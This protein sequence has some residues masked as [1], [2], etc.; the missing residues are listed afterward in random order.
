MWQSGQVSSQN[1]SQRTPG[2]LQHGAHLPQSAG[3]HGVLG[4]SPAGL[5]GQ[6]QGWR[7][8]PAGGSA[9]PAASQQFATAGGLLLQAQYLPVAVSLP[10]GLSSAGLQ[11]QQP[12]LLSPAQYSLGT[13][14]VQTLPQAVQP[15]QWASAQTQPSAW[16]ISHSPPAAQQQQLAQQH[17]HS[18]LSHATAQLQLQQHLHLHTHAHPQLHQQQLQL[19]QQQQHQ[20][21]Q[22][23]H[24][25]GLALAPQPGGRGWG[26]QHLPYG[27]T[28]ALAAN[29]DAR[30][31]G[32]R[33][34]AAGGG[35]GG[36]G[37][38][39]MGY[40]QG[41]GGRGGRGGG[42]T[43]GA[44]GAGG[45][46]AGGG[47]YGRGSG[48]GGSW[49][50][51]YGSAGGSSA[52][53]VRG[54]YGGGGGG[55]GGGYG[56]GGGGG[57]SGVSGPHVDALIHQLFMS[58]RQLPR[59]QPA[60]EA[61]A[62]R[63]GGLDGRSVAALMKQL[64]T[65]GL[66]GAA[67]EIF[68]WLRGLDHGHELDRLLDVYLFTAM[69]SLCSSNRR[70]LD[71]ALS[72][73]REMVARGVP[74]NV[75]TF[76]ALMNVCIKAGQHQAALDVWR[77]LQEAG[78]RPNVV[79]YNTLIDVYG[80]TGQWAEALKVLARMKE[81]GMEPVTRTY[82]T[83]MIACN[84][85]NQWHEALSVY[86]QLVAAGQAPNTTTYNALI[87][88]YS[89]AGRLEKVMETLREME[90]AGCER[91]VITYSALISACE[92]DGQWELA[93]QMFGQMLREG[94]NPN[95][96]TYNSLITALAA[97]AQWERAADV[98]NQL[99]RQGC[100]P[101]VVTYTALIN[102]YEKGGQWRRA[103]QAFKRLLQQGCRTDHV[104]FAAIA[105][106]LWDSG[107]ASAHARAA[108]IFRAAVAS[109]AIKPVTAAPPPSASSGATSTAGTTSTNSSGAVPVAGAGGVPPAA[110][111]A[112]GAA[113]ASGSGSAAGAGAGSLEP[114][115]EVHLGAMASGSCVAAF[116][117]F[118][119]EQRDRAIEGGPEALPPRVVLRFARAR[120]GRDGG[121]LLPLRDAL[122]AWLAARGAPFKLAQDFGPVAA[123][124][125]EALGPDLAAWLFSDAAA[126][127]LLPFAAGGAGAP[128]GGAAGG[129][130][131]ALVQA[132]LEGVDEENSRDAALEA[133]C[134]D[135]FAEVRA[136]EATH[137]LSVAAMG[138]AYLAR[139]RELTANLLDVHEA[140]VAAAAGG[141]AGGAGG[142]GSAGGVGGAGAGGPGGA[143][144]GGGALPLPRVAVH[145]AVLLLDRFMSS[146]PALQDNLLTMAS[147]TALRMLASA[148]H[149]AEH[150]AAAGHAGA[151]AAAEAAEAALDGL[152][153]AVTGLPTLG[154]Q[155]MEVNVRSA[156][157]GD[158]AAISA[159][160]CVRLYLRR[161]GAT[162]E[163]AGEAE[164]MELLDAALLDGEFLNYR[165]S[166]T[167]A[168]A[169]YAHRLRRG[170]TPPWPAAAAAL[171]GYAD[172]DHPELAAA[173]GAVQRLLME[174]SSSAAYAA[175]SRGAGAG[176]RSS[177]DVGAGAGA[178]AQPA[179]A[180]SPD[181]A[182]GGDEALGPEAAA[183]S[184]EA[185]DAG[186]GGT[187]AA[188]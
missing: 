149:A 107:T 87:T 124:R 23:V 140:V 152:L 59:G 131:Q 119:A 161:L 155:S 111:E 64:S 17:Q 112:G 51:G 43:G 3:E 88:A 122:Q 120:G 2:S 97:G 179:P 182:T 6:L 178:R 102:A 85:S 67:W 129:G 81:E 144:G 95:I 98:F 96:I 100:E 80:K 75:H 8:L 11:Q 24:P 181:G 123:Q 78:C 94:C 121:S 1:T 180:A 116:M 9:A 101:D 49:R 156:L 60:H 173:V 34:G 5:G 82:N 146:G 42:H 20:Q 68:D 33:D 115:Q 90:A 133:D 13:A 138:P 28:D 137:C 171:T 21:Q 104:V 103:L 58:V 41:R 117:C 29:T 7:I 166:A 135:A 45:Y 61:V 172:L 35:T 185:G 65:N 148:E 154:F 30:S 63:M 109:G 76:S 40:G 71:V 118:L 130:T 86:A 25:P 46:G 79:T 113:G 14:A 162:P 174:M 26:G 56:G 18:Q 92:R 10:P 153:A 183:A 32:G 50:G 70:D 108:R 69:I 188:Q 114:L 163:A 16:A 106:A 141:A 53:S 77:E 91:T 159:G 66:A 164:L 136:F 55:Y 47:R 37:A 128:E 27:R 139:R 73:S 83:L 54:G 150:A 15:Q 38:G 12:T 177:A 52:G 160:R 157:A 127:E 62:S 168:A 165:P 176:A 167:A 132:A 48:G 4:T 158:T 31:S 169:L 145:D 110:A 142:G 72:L 151:A 44:G 175:S 143:G 184:S 170:D 89:K 57:S 74:R 22:L 93:L 126:L 147:V 105:D 134:R 84:S 36:G 186:N 19:P 39:G 125:L 99:Q 187:V